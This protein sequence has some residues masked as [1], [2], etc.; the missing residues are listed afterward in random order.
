MY[1]YVPVTLHTLPCL[2]WR[3]VKTFDWKD[4]EVKPP[5]TPPLLAR[6]CVM[7]SYAA[8]LD[9]HPEEEEEE[10]D[11]EAEPMQIIAN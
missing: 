8:E 6:P 10:E 3:Q 5:S 1:K 2:A 11:Q 4:W 9:E 7:A